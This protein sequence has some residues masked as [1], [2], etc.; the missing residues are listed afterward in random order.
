MSYEQEPLFDDRY[1]PYSEQELIDIRL[2]YY[3]RRVVLI[4]DGEKVREWKVGHSFHKNVNETKH[5]K[6]NNSQGCYNSSK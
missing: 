5:V 4:R 3:S 6:H 1:Q 2:Q